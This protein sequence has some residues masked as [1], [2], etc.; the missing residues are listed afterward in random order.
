MIVVCQPVIGKDCK[1]LS[2]KISQRF[3]PNLLI[4]YEFLHHISD[5]CPRC[6]LF[7]INI[8]RN[9][10]FFSHPLTGSSEK[11]HFPIQSQ[12][13]QQLIFHHNRFDVLCPDFFQSRT[14]SVL[15]YDFGD[16]PLCFTKCCAFPSSNL[17]PINHPFCKSFG[18]IVCFSLFFCQRPV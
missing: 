13:S 4:L 17:D 14:R 15:L 1:L 6:F 7:H 8:Q 12:C 16:I 10:D 9:V 18:I 5:A 2:C 11:T 3:I